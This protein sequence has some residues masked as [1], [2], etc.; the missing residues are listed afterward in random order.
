MIE[1]IEKWIAIILSAVYLTFILSVYALNTKLKC[2]FIFV[3]FC[4]MGVTL[5]WLRRRFIPRS[6]WSTRLIAILVSGALLF[7]FQ[8]FFLPL[9]KENLITLSA[10]GTDGNRPDKEVWFTVI[11]SDGKRVPLADVEIEN[12]EHWTFVSEYDSYV[13]YPAENVT[14]NWLTLRVVAKN[15]TLQ[16]ERNDWSGEVEIQDSSGTIS[17]LNLASEEQTPMLYHIRTAREYTLWQ[18]ALLNAG[19]FLVLYFFIEALCSVI[20]KFRK[21]LI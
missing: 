14:V 16:L 12:N 8:D 15:V 4:V 9:D 6:K 20:F 11:E 5:F 17:R 2:V 7:G 18:R 10:I 13:F 21:S 19:A 3:Y 1:K